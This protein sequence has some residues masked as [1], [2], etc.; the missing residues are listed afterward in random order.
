MG[1]DKPLSQAMSRDEGMKGHG[2]RYVRPLDKVAVCFRRRREAFRSSHAVKLATEFR[3]Q[4]YSSGVMPLP[5]KEVA[6][7]R[8]PETS[9][10][11][12]YKRT[13]AIP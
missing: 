7:C 1:C 13:H 5:D 4:S 12:A 8:A 11:A 6:Q 3:A 2:C 9:I 10:P